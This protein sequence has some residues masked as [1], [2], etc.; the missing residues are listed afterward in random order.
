MESEAGLGAPGNF[1]ASFLFQG[2]VG[3]GQ[4]SQGHFNDPEIRMTEG[5]D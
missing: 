2:E 3:K 1:L 5:V 4:K